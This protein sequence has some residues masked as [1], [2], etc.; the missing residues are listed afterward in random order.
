MVGD[1]DVGDVREFFHLR[2]PQ[3]RIAQQ[4]GDEDER[5]IIHVRQRGRLPAL[6]RALMRERAAR[7]S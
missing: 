5:K 6:P 3:L 2:L 1:P 4:A 7:T